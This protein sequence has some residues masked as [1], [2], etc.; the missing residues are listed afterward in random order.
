MDKL[1]VVGTWVV[2]VLL[3]VMFVMIG[4][5]KFM[6]LEAWQAR[7]ADQWGLPVWLV[8]LIGA[9]EVIGGV[10][11]LVPKFA[12]AGGLLIVLVMLGATGTHLSAAEWPNAGFTV[13]LGALAVF[14]AYQR[15]QQRAQA[16]S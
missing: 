9:M 10:M 8:P 2:A 4:S 1:K 11:L 3:A 12:P 5:G 7:F 6:E 16:G 14:V 15:L 13:V